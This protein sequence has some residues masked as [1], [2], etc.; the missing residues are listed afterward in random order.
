MTEY[1]KAAEIMAISS[2]SLC[3]VAL[4]AATYFQL[5]GMA[6]VHVISL[7]KSLHMHCPPSSSSVLLLTIK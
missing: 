1:G 7:D 2:I 3:S 6:P 4:R 5:L